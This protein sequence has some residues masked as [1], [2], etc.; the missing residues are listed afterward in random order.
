MHLFRYAN[1]VSVSDEVLIK[2]NAKLMPAKVINVS[3]L[4]LQG[5]L[6]FILKSYVVINLIISIKYLNKII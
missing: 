5:D 2:D 3:S 6:N 4:I 1:E